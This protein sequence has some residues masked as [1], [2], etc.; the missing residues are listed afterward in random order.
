MAPQLG[1]SRVGLLPQD[2]WIPEA[3]PFSSVF[4]LSEMRT[5][6]YHGGDTSSQVPLI[7]CGLK[8]SLTKIL[9]E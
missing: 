4:A 1:S 7:L 3:L 9:L 8:W 5:G 6:T 2:L